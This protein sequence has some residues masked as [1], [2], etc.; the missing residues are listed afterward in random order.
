ME[1]TDSQN[2]RSTHR[3][4]HFLEFLDEQQSPTMMMVWDEKGC[5]QSAWISK[6]LQQLYGLTAA[7][8]I[9]KRL[10]DLYSPSEANRQLGLTT[11]AIRLNSVV[12]GVSHFSNEKGEFWQ[13]ATLSPSRQPSGDSMIMC[14]IT[15][16]TARREEENQFKRT[17]TTHP[18][19]LHR[20]C[21][22]L[23]GSLI[24]NEFGDVLEVNQKLCE[25]LG[26]SSPAD[27]LTRISSVMEL[28]D[29]PNVNWDAKDWQS[30]LGKPIEEMEVDINCADQSL[31]RVTLYKYLGL[32]EGPASKSHFFFLDPELDIHT[33]HTARTDT[34]YL[35]EILANLPST[36]ID[37]YN[38]QG[39]MISTWCPNS[40]EKRLGFPIS[41]A[42]QGRYL[43]DFMVDLE[44]QRK[45]SLF[46][47]ILDSESLYR[48]EF[49]FNTPHSESWF[50]VSAVPIKLSTGE[51]FV[52]TSFTD[53]TERKLAEEERVKSEIQLQ[54]AQKMEAIGRIS[55]GIA[56]DFGNRL[57]IV[58]G[59]G[60]LIKGLLKGNPP[61]QEKLAALV[62]A[63]K[64]A[65][66][67]TK[68]LLAFTRNDVYHDTRI[69]LHE[70]LRK[71]VDIL[72]HSLDKRVSVHTELKAESVALTADPTQIQNIFLNLMINA[73]DAMPTG[74]ELTVRTKNRDLSGNEPEL[75]NAAI[76]FGKFIVTTVKD[77]GVGIATDQLSRIFEP[78]YT[79]KTLGK[80][81]GLGLSVVE[82]TVKN[83]HGA[84]TVNSKV[85][86]GTTFTVYLPVL[87]KVEHI[88]TYEDADQDIT[89]GTGNVLIVDD[90]VVVLQMISDCLQAAGYRVK[91]QNNPVGALQYLRAHPGEVDLA[92]LDL[93]MP[94]MNG[95]EL[96]VAM[97][98][99]SPN[100]KVVITSA[101]SKEGMV[102]DILEAG[103]AG[104]IE[105]PMTAAGLTRL[106]AE[107][108]TTIIERSSCWL[109]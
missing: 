76:S 103:A 32:N 23:F 108:M 70:Q 81:T 95:K 59:Y 17:T 55:A 64:Q 36:R 73:A 38:R 92:I 104:F 14:M 102:N 107:V 109:P 31:K 65:S 68:Q 34:E 11:R 33:M 69:D 82:G 8:F 35:L 43:Y 72:E 1:K 46:E 22:H 27:L 90:E 52:I 58:L 86:K 3:D 80:G 30:L 87:E 94:E 24:C 18:E 40:Q 16:I 45:I 61:L 6:E 101:Y 99:I 85:D 71:V 56:H 19:F 84:I 51:E 66:A 5:I 105:K 44:A 26:D 10:H 4:S 78:F 97:R 48:E 74:G 60:T 89:S 67:L 100:L 83:Y 79:T 47:D 12:R 88:V 28:I 63:T 13:D 21:D 62:Q 37:V 50:D 49:Y 57:S 29:F 53:I 75:Q 25:L 15:D 39:Q 93:M 41:K 77:T 98:E 20:E 2:H 54:Q 106:I 9:D 42:S 7:D 96:Y 91:I